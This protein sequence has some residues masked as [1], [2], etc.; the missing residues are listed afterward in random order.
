[1][2]FFSEPKL[3]RPEITKRVI[4]FVLALWMG[5]GLAATGCSADTEEDTPIPAD[6][7][8]YG[9][10]IARELCGQFPY[11]KAYS[12]QEKGA[13]DF[14]KDAFSA[15]GYSVEEQVFTA[16][17]GLGYSTN[18]IVR[19]SG[20]GFMIPNEQG[21]LTPSNK[22]VIV[23]AHYD[24][25]YGQEDAQTVPDFDGIQDNAC[26]I[27]A[28][29]TLAQQIAE[30]KPAYD[31]I[32][33]AFG[34]GNDQFSGARAFLGAMSQEE[35][36][37]CD[38]MY[39]IESIF[40]GDK[41]YASSGMN[42]VADNMKYAMRRKLYEAYDVC[43]DGRL[44]YLYGVDLLY[45]QSGQQINLDADPYMEIY[46]EVTLTQSDYVPFD[47]AGIPI[48]FFESYDYNFA[49]IEE[50]KETKNLDL[51]ENGGLIRRTNY[52]S[53]ET[54]EASLPE[55]Q[56]EKRINATAYIILGAIMKGTHIGV[57]MSDYEAGVTLAPSPTQ[58]S[59]TSFAG[60]A[61]ITP[62]P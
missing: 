55:G 40:A 41:L 62:V 59:E 2:P 61:S 18:Y 12:A 45:N 8:Q 33:V 7:G 49:K 1:M 43:Y 42:S 46:R 47:S 38:A 58:P 19:I 56:L 16:A 25:V 6:F 15:L 60:T 35:I 48:V 32:L 22:T 36:E 51:Q 52:D 31:V 3:R 57:S 44:S 50:M 24:T 23:G 30:A 37:A 39:C 11:R 13:G 14:I 27:G 20:E 54:L 21:I 28:L 17:S 9:A 5:I 26:G 29:L 10:D 53:L 34:A 4:C